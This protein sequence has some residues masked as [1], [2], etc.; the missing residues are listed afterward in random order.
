[1]LGKY[2]LNQIVEATKSPLKNVTSSW[3]LVYAA[4]QEFGIGNPNTEIAAIATIATETGSFLPIYEKLADPIKQPDLY[5]SQQRYYPSGYYGRGF[6]QLTWMDN[7]KIYGNAL[8]VDLLK[9]PNLAL[10]PAIA[11]RIL[12]YFFKKTNIPVAAVSNNWQKVRKLVN[13]GLTGYDIFKKVVDSL[14]LLKAFEPHIKV[15]IPEELNQEKLYPLRDSQYYQNLHETDLGYQ[16]NNWLLEDLE[17]ILSF[18]ANSLLELAC[19]NGKFLELCSSYFE[20]IYGCD[21]AISPNIKS[22]LEKFPNVNFF[23]VDLYKDLLP[24]KVDLVVSADFLEHLA[25]EAL[26]MVLQKIDSLSTKAYH[27][28]ACYD[29]GHSHLSILSPKEWLEL[30]QTVNSQYQ[31]EKVEL[32]NPEQEVVVLSKGRT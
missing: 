32:R 16:T 13:G 10:D 3:P 17:I 8:K 23:Q 20:T 27:K 11:A 18:K 12:A 15:E 7:Y 19:G 28:I 4:L 2:T 21:W 9:N 29:D 30:F 1:M 6:V 31:L 5:K 24:C 14:L 25:P 26:P 22:I